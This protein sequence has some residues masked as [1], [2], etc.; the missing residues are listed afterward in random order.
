M[1]GRFQKVASITAAFFFGGGLAVAT[2]AG[3]SPHMRHPHLKRKSE[4]GYKLPYRPSWV[5]VIKKGRLFQYNRREFSSPVVWK[6]LV[7]LGA[8]NGDFYA[9]K[10]D[11]GRKQW[12]IRGAGSI[13]S[14]PAVDSERVFFGDDKGRLYAV[15]LPQGQKLWE[16]E[17]G[18]ELL[19]QPAVGD[20]RVIVAT[21][22]GKVAAF[23]TNDGAPLW[24]IQHLSSPLQ[25]TIYGNSPP[26]LDRDGRVYIGFADGTFWS[27]RAKD[28]K[29]LWE[30]NFSPTGRFADLD[31]TPIIDGGRIYL[32]A[33]DGP[34]VAISNTGRLLWSVPV[35]T[36]V[37][38]L[39]QGD[40]LY[41]ADS[42]GS[43][44]ALRKDDGSEVWKTTLGEG[45]LTSPVLHK[46]ILAV[47]LSQSTMNFIDSRNGTLMFRRFA[48]R[49]ISSDPVLVDDRICYFS[50]SGRLYSLKWVD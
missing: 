21:V 42:R 4:A 45:A 5:S 33:F 47:G 20:G 7:L 22:E 10:A 19:S 41:V 49:G 12:R 50:N 9:L 32:A 6:D 28:G 18:S 14:K 26:I 11:S 8:D 27:L 3:D 29:V 48:R 15:S 25:M 13:H 17:V 40:R 44:R 46:D 16:R 1:A 2:P 38:L 34:L 35:G 39:S 37:S 31:A 24:E 23:R 30:R 36:G 43:L